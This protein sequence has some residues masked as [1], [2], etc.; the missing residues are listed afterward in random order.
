MEERITP[1]PGP[2][3]MATPS[4]SM[5]ITDALHPFRAPRL[6]AAALAS[7]ALLLCA[8]PDES[9]AQK[10][11]PGLPGAP[12]P[13]STNGSTL[14]TLTLVGEHDALVPG[15]ISWIGLHFRIHEGWHLYWRNNGDTGAPMQITLAA[16]EGVE[17]GDIHYPAPRRHPVTGGFLD[18]VYE[19]EVTL[20]VPVRVPEDRRAGETIDV[21]AS[22]SWLIC[23]DVCLAGEG[24]S[25]IE[26]PIRAQSHPT[27]RVP[28]FERARERVPRPMADAWADGIR[29]AW[30]APRRLVIT[31]PGARALAFFPYESEANA[32]PED[33]A[34]QGAVDADTI[35]LRYDE[36]A[37][38]AERVAGVLEVRSPGRTSWYEIVVEGPSSGPG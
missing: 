37:D 36:H 20:L 22:V 24:E 5:S 35:S 21:R 23:N 17:I 34:T 12:T 10:S 9:Q 25:S 18:F 28:L 4:M 2:L 26:L 1:I 30:R 32:Y 11:L 19:G 3:E 27:P 16:S 7:A 14:A 29:V 13:A 31:A 6:D 15:V 8:T 38:E 33:M